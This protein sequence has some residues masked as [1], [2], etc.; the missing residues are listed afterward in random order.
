MARF[1]REAQLLAALNHPNIGGI[2]GL[3]EADGQPN[4]V[5]E[6]VPGETLGGCCSTRRT[7]WRGAAGRGGGW[8][9]GG[10]RGDW[11]GG[12]SARWGCFWARVWRAGQC[13]GGHSRRPVRWLEG[14]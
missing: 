4:L 9:S 10:R 7:N 2:Y 1:E 8:R 5:L 6:F 12:P 14:G 11:F 13:C 3:E